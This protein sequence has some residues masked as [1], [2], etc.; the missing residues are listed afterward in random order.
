MIYL[1]AS[2]FGDV[3]FDDVVL[4][5]DGKNAVLIIIRRSRERNFEGRNILFPSLLFELLRKRF[6]NHHI[7]RQS[8]HELVLVV[9]I[10]KALELRA[11]QATKTKY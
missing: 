11:S 2:T 6:H 5:E 9:Q 7:F 1:Q 4:L 10:S 8:C 3:Q